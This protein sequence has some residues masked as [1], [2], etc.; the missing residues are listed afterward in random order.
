VVWVKV[1][2]QLAMLRPDVNLAMRAEL[3]ASFGSNRE[4]NVRL[5]PKLDISGLSHDI[6]PQCDERV[7]FAHQR[8]FTVINND[9]CAHTHNYVY[10]YHRTNK[11]LDRVLW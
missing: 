1:E 5:R 2:N 7:P 3:E 9:D 11:V 10:A 4:R 6:L 8:R